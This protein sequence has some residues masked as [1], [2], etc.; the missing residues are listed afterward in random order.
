MKRLQIVSGVVA[1]AMLSVCSFAFQGAPAQSQPLKP[2]ARKAAPQQT[3]TGVISD[4]QCA[5]KGSHKEIM[6]K[7]SVNTAANCTK[8]C[9]RRYGYVLYDP[10]TKRIYK[11]ADQEGPAE[12][13]D[14]R[15]RIKGRLDKNTQTIYASSIE[16]R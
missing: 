9:A 14:K 2:P 4:R 11:L 16:P 8:G 1:S 5:G 10:A 7:A 15:V 6:K 12:L 3:F 13:A